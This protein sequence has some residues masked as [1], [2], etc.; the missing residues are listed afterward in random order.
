MAQKK[1]PK[2]KVIVDQVVISPPNMKV[3]PLTLVGTTPYVQH[4]FSQ[5]AI[6]QMKT[7][8]EMG[9]QSKK[10]KKREPRNWEADYLQSMHISTEGWNGVPASC[11]RA[12][13]I[14]ACRLVG[15]KMTLA[16]LSIFIEAD[17]VDKVDGMPLVKI[18]GDPHMCEHCVRLPT[19]GTTD[20]RIRAMWDEWKIRLRI[21]FDADVFSVS[22]VVN[23]MS[24]CGMQVGIGEGR[25]DSKSGPGVGWGVFRI[26][27]GEA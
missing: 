10:G 22:D 3:L 14:S 2:D 18:E 26:D 1:E 23:L 19:S 11:F 16:K 13:M 7:A 9:S 15:F 4:R 27:T 25:P 8:Q 12:A 17:G 24:R 6:T 21:R 5:K 20:I